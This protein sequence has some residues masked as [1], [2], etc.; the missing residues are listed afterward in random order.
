MLT[1]QNVT[2]QK[3][4]AFPMAEKA[5]ANVEKKT[6]IRQGQR[7]IAKRLLDQ[8]K[9]RLSG[10]SGVSDRQWGKESL[11]ALQEKIETLK[12]LDNQILD[13]IGGLE[14]EDL[15][16]LIE[17]EIE[18][19]DRFRGEL[20]QVV[21][22]LEEVLNPSMH[23][24]GPASTGASSQNEN[25]HPANPVHNM[26]A[27][28]PKL[29]VKRFN[30]RLQ[31]WQEFWDSFQSSIDGNDNLSAVDKFSY[32]KSLVQE[33]ARSTI[34]GF[35]LTAVNYDAA[36]QALKKRYG[37]EIAI[38]RAHVNDLLNLSPVYTDR[39]I[40]RLRKLFDECE[41]HFRGLKALGVEEITYSTIVVPAIMQK[42]PEGFRLTITRG[43]E[44]LTWSMEQMLQAFLKELELREDHFYAMTSSK[45]LHSNKLD[46]K[47]NRTKGATANALFTKQEHGNCAFCLG[48][49][50]HE[51]CQRVKDPKERKNIV[52]KFARCFIC[53]KKGHRARE[54]KAFDV[55]C[56]KCGQSGHHVSLCDVRIVQSVPPV[57]EFQFTPYG[58]NKTPT[59][60][61]PSSLHVGTGG[62]VA[63]QTARAVIRGEGEPYRVRVLFDAGSHRSFITFKAAQRAQLARIRQEW[64]GISTFGQRSKDMRLRDVVEA[65]VSPING[66]KVIPIEAYV[67]PEISSIQNSHVE[68][69]KGQYPH[70]KDLWFSDVCVGAGELEIDILIGADCLWSFQKDCTIR[71]G[72]DEPV[73]VETEL[74]W[75]LSGPMKS[76][77]SGPEPVQI[78]LVQ[79]E[80]KGGLDVDVNRMWDLETIEIKE[81]RSGVYEEYRDSISFDG[82]RYS[83]KLPWKEG[84]PDLPTNYTTSIRRLK[85]QVARLEREPKS[86]QNMQQ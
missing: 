35:A 45:L 4:R 37:K 71:G 76:Q 69:V 18:E 22:R 66:Q 39:D 11:Q 1:N 26:K 21:L 79:T 40:P 20:N 75:V 6:R 16:V 52:F 13:L 24:A 5:K 27:K 82:Q 72:L 15:D 77:S 65:K 31:D 7:N 41:S 56:S 2:K 73:A 60:A 48:K 84:H 33:P 86:S 85:S 81:P 30:G 57:A 55:L 53:M 54:C 46:G 50:A 28:L 43:E 42:L 17:R 64:L 10:G 32:L 47:D 25:A 8:V 58:Q 9:Q 3:E 14:S 83:V 51:N 68:F 29:E 34:A 49:H 63:L 80:D 44:F 74:G 67:V 23:S 78:N 70:L 61:S 36:V 62:R 12:K 38:Q 59:T 19:S